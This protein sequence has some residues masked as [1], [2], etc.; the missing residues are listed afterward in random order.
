MFSFLA[1]KCYTISYIFANKGFANTTRID[2]LHQSVNLKLSICSF[3][4]R[5]PESIFPCSKHSQEPQE[6]D[7][8]QIMVVSIYTHLIQIH[9]NANN[10]LHFRIHYMYISYILHYMYYKMVYYNQ[11]EIVYKQKHKTKRISMKV[12]NSRGRSRTTK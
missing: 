1:N 5:S 11:I 2:V 8:E 6:T 12:L 7:T 4:L 3:V 10:I 9:I